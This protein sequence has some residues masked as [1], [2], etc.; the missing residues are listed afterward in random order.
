[1]CKA[2]PTIDWNRKGVEVYHPSHADIVMIRTEDI[3][4]DAEFITPHEILQLQFE[5]LDPIPRA[6]HHQ[7]RVHRGNEQ[8][9]C[10]DIELSDMAKNSDALLRIGGYRGL[11]LRIVR[12]LSHRREYTVPI[13]AD[14]GQSG[15]R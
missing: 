15:R 9:G 4:F 13:G 5:Y 8:I 1:M 2:L 3:M 14:V 10:I 7:I 12:S 6:E 11:Y